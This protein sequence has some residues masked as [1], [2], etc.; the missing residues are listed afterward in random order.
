MASQ[1][2]KPER[3]GPVL[4]VSDESNPENENTNGFNKP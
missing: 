4:H 2:L 3:D 1:E